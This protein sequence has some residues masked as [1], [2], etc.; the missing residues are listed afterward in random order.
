MTCKDDCLHYE[1]CKNQFGDTDYFDDEVITNDVENY[2][3]KFEDKSKYIKLPCK[4]GDTV[5]AI[6]RKEIVPLK[7]SS[8]IYTALGLMVEAVDEYGSTLHFDKYNYIEWFLTKEE[9]EQKLKE[10]SGSE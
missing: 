6:L 2:C 5:Y 8:F 10:M 4:V 1:F 9:A 3:G 7:V